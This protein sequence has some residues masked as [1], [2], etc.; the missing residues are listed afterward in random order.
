M[1]A[2]LLRKYLDIVLEAQM[3]ASPVDFTQQALST[4]IAKKVVPKGDT[5]GYTKF[6]LYFKALIDRPGYRQVDIRLHGEGPKVQPV[7]DS[8][9]VLDSRGQFI[10]QGDTNTQQQRLLPNFLQSQ[11]NR[12][13][14][15]Q[16]E[17]VK[18]TVWKTVHPATTRGG[19]GAYQA[20]AD[21][22]ES[23]INK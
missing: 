19:A 17:A 9:A 16:K 18:S 2:E 21:Y 14:P 20:V 8:I 23:K 6:Q 3:S 5:T 22:A 13:S 15:Q 12:F 10:F 4:G 7:D 1:S 11:T